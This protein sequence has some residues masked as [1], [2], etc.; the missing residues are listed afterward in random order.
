MLPVIF[1]IIPAH[2]SCSSLLT[3]V[4]HHSVFSECTGC[5]ASKLC[6]SYRIIIP[7]CQRLQSSIIPVLRVPVG[8][9]VVQTPF[10]EF[11]QRSRPHPPRPHPFICLS[12][13][14][15]SFE[16]LARHVRRL[17][18][19]VGQKPHQ[20]PALELALIPERSE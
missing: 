8:R 9:R 2:F 18:D 4:D 16:D 6:K 5:S 12:P 15:A 14:N 20:P 7:S 19:R 1:S 3:I 13:A 10:S 11:T 17:T